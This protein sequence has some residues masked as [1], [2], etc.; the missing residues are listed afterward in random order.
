MWTYVS[1]FGVD[2][3]IAPKRWFTWDIDIKGILESLCHRT[4]ETT[5]LVQSDTLAPTAVDATLRRSWPR[6]N[7]WSGLGASGWDAEGEQKRDTRSPPNR[8]SWS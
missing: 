5:V 3:T 1:G 7:P 8:V 2:G 4:S 6:S